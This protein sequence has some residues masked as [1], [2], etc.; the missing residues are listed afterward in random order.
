MILTFSD[1]LI[2]KKAQNCF[3]HSADSSPSRVTD[4][5]GPKLNAF[6][7]HPTWPPTSNKSDWSAHMARGNGNG[8]ESKTQ[9]GKWELG[10]GNGGPISSCVVEMAAESAPHP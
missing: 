7:D 9:K 2:D 3:D 8:G 6:M 4:R 5:S 10:G 1:D